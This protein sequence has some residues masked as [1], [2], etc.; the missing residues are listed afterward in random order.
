MGFF[1]VLLKCYESGDDCTTLNILKTTE[2]FMLKECILWYVKCMLIKV[3][4]N[5]IKLYTHTQTGTG[6]TG[7][8]WMRN[9]IC[10]NVNILVMIL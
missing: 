6:K 2:L 5:S 7:W 4:W 8:I 3:S 9:I 10:I 1:W